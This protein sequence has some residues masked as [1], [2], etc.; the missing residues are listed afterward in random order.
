[1]EC[2]VF[3]E[4]IYPGQTCDLD[5]NDDQAESGGRCRDRP[6]PARRTTHR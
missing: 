2:I 3:V 1:M 4:E 6:F 5:V